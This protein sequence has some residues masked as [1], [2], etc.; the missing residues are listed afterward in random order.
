MNIIL[1]TEQCNRI[2]DALAN[3]QQSQSFADSDLQARH[4]QIQN[5]ICLI[6]NFFRRL[7]TMVESNEDKLLLNHQIYVG[8]NTGLTMDANSSG[9][10]PS[11]L[12]GR[13]ASAN[14]TL[15]YTG[16][17]I[18]GTKSI[19]PFF[20]KAGISAIEG[21]V[22]GKARFRI[23]KDKKLY[24]ELSLQAQ[25]DAHLAAA[26]VMGGVNLGVVNSSI[27][28]TAE[29]GAV[30]GH[31]TAVLTPEKQELSAQV[32]AAAVRGECVLAIEL[33]DIKVSI[34]VSGSL[35]SV[36]AGIHYSNEPGSWEIGANGA[37]FAGGGLRIRVDY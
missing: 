37:L 17:L 18:G 2:A 34:G 19:G 36:E 14:A 29:V 7:S 20:G 4:Q 6:E 22:S 28:T 13:A 11:L 33:A 10:I 1:D 26:S 27:Q 21:N 31:A 3:L 5:Q 32:G 23:T 16:M 30:Y 8:S 9:S 12:K 24:P 25:G 15:A 35:G